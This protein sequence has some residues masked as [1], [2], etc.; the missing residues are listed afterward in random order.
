MGN[1]YGPYPC[2]RL[3]QCQACRWKSDVIGIKLTMV[4]IVTSNCWKHATSNNS[5]FVT[6]NHYNAAIQLL[7]T[8]LSL[9]LPRPPLKLM[10]NNTQ[11]RNPWLWQFWSSTLLLEAGTPMETADYYGKLIHR[12]LSFTVAAVTCSNS[13][14]HCSTFLQITHM[15]NSAGGGRGQLNQPHLY[16]RKAL[17]ANSSSEDAAP[18]SNLICTVC[19]RRCAALIGL[20]AHMRT[21]SRR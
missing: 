3:Q 10:T 16:C 1:G 18:S 21:H 17:L 4:T 15:D 11:N 13:A 8:R 6:P 14:H 7:H 2:G 9:T 19:G 20:T 12:E 5:S